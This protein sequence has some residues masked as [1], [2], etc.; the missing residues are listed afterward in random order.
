MFLISCSFKEV[1]ALAVTTEFVE[2]NNDSLPLSNGSSILV[3]STLCSSALDSESA[4]SLFFSFTKSVISK[5]W[6]FI[7]EI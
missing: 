2:E 7:Y 4:D 6:F 3:S 5:S 1:L